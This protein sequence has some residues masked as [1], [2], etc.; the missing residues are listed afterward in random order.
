MG[1]TGKIPAILS[2]SAASLALIQT[3]MLSKGE[4]VS[5]PLDK[6]GDLLNG[7]ENLKTDQVILEPPLQKDL[8]RLYADHSSHASHSSH[9]SGMSDSTYSAPTYTVP[10]TAPTPVYPSYTPAPAQSVTPPPPVTTVPIET[11]TPTANATPT[12]GVVTDAAKLSYTDSLKKEAA[13]GSADAQ[14]ALSIYYIYG[15]N[16]C[17]KNHE[18]AKML[19][20]LAAV[21]GDVKAQQRLDKLLEDDK[22]Q[23]TK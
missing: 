19:L 17:E 20:E 9:T 18:K 3:T 7:Q 16:G 10:D 8:L 22:A 23:A 14:Y 5:G 11:N 13:Q 15:E 2:L 12:N 6:S 21:Q 1:T 4:S